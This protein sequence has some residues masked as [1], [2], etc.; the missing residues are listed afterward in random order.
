MRA[1]RGWLC[2]AAATLLTFG[3]AD[4]ATNGGGGF[5]DF[6]TTRDA[7]TP[8]MGGAGGNAPERYAAPG[9]GGAPGQGGLP[10]A[11]CGPAGRR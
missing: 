2:V 5:A 11:L 7:G 8:G 1:T 4:D 10:G 9:A 3:C 6:G